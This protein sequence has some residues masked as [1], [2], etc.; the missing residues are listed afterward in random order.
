[1]NAPIRYS[2]REAQG[3]I[4]AREEAAAAWRCEG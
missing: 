2:L 4:E 1:M 3:R